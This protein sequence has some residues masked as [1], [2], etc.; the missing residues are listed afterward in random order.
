[1]RFTADENWPKFYRLNVEKKTKIVKKSISSYTFCKFSS[2]LN[3]Q[4]SVPLLC[5]NCKR[6]YIL[7]KEISLKA[8]PHFLPLSHFDLL[9][10]KLLEH[11]GVCENRLTRPKRGASCS[12]E[13]DRE[14]KK[15]DPAES[16][17]TKSRRIYNFHRRLNKTKKERNN[18]STLEQSGALRDTA[19]HSHQSE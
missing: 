4:N 17:L 14:K 10:D 18:R 19:G 13:A 5:H 16:L 6:K 12:C 3:I 2:R 7:Q 9:S 11:D 15:K 1:M 8:A